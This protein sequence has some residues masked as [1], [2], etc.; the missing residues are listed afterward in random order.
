[1]T[2]SNRPRVEGLH[3]AGRQNADE[4]A[5]SCTPTSRPRSLTRRSLLQAGAGMALAQIGAGPAQAVSDGAEMAGNVPF[6]AAI[7]AEYFPQSDYRQA[8]LDHCDLVMPM[9]ELKFDQIRPQ[10]EAWN[11]EA[12]DKLVGF[13]K[14]HGKLSRGTCHVWWNGTPAWIDA[15]DGAAAAEAALIEHIE[16]VTDRYRGKLLGWDVVNEVIAND[17]LQEGPLRRTTWLQK[18][19]PR[20]IPIAFTAAANADPAARLVI[21]DYD[22]EF[23]GPRYDARRDVLLTILR[24]LQDRNVKVTGVGIQG[25]LYADRSID[26]KALEVLHRTLDAMGI[27]MLI[28]ELDVIDWESKPGDEPQDETAY[29]LVSDLLDGAFAW[30]PPAAVVAWGL[31][32]RHSWVNDVLP[33]PDGAPSRPLPLDRAY[34]PKNWLGLIQERLQQKA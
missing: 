22:L 30:K 19:G 3:A 4:A 13:A 12:A 34:K 14:E 29:R 10:R 28:T 23:A 33:R 31:S 11:F 9:N 2:G 1:M 25:H 17:P 20:H 24:Q 32:D 7:Q 5:G 18:L 15:L 6:G 21:N 26:K 8:F 16:R 27:E